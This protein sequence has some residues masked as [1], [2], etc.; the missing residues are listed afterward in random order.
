MENGENHQDIYLVTGQLL[1]LDLYFQDLYYLE[2][3]NF[4]ILNQ[5]YQNAI[6]QQSLHQY[7]VHSPHQQPSFQNYLSTYNT[8]HIKI[9]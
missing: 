5:F 8:N 7:S 1:L 4:T 3:L 2:E 6:H 9:K